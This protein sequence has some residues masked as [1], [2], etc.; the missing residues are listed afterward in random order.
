MYKRKEKKQRKKSSLNIKDTTSQLASLSKQSDTN[1]RA[2]N[3]KF[4]FIAHI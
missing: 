3:N 1:Q 4:L 2:D